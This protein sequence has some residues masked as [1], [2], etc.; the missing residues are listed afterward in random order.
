MNLLQP[1]DRRSLA[2]GD[3][4][5]AV[6]ARARLLAAG[7]GSALFDELCEVVR[8]LALPA[9]AVIL[10]LGS[11]TGRL[12]AEVSESTGRGA[13]ACFGIDLSAPAVELAARTYGARCTW[14][15]ANADRRLPLVD[16]AAALVLSV[17]GR[18]N[19]AEV[20]RVLAP[21]GRWLIAVP[22]GD[23]LAELRAA[24]QGAAPERR[25]DEDVLAELAALPP[26]T[27]AF[28]VERRGTSS[29]V[30]QLDR[31]AI[32]DACAGTY[33]GL[34]AAEAARLAALDALHVTFASHWLL[35]RR[36]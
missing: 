36:A 1:Q 32:A 28:E 14:I 10:E 3:S 26:G 9:G 21:G 15:I 31:A 35:L 24:A 23:D 19:P 11:G 6:A 5:E 2:A 22:A 16:G 12:L 25:R 17:H 27:A 7:H 33:R 8:E 30:R 29:A 13:P 34:R 20:A 4:R 18:R